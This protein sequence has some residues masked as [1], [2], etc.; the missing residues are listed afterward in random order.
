MDVTAQGRGRRE[1]GRGKKTQSTTSRDPQRS[2]GT[3]CAGMT[4]GRELGR[5]QGKGEIPLVLT[6]RKA[7]DGEDGSITRKIDKGK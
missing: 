4:M 2:T 3:C 6:G 1:G 5:G 7:K